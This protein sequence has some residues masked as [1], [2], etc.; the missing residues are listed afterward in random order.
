MLHGRSLL[1]RLTL[2][3]CLFFA[4]SYAADLD[5]TGG[6]AAPARVRFLNAASA[7]HA[8][9]EGGEGWLNV[10]TR[11]AAQDFVSAN[12]VSLDALGRRL[13]ADESL[14]SLQAIVASQQATIA[15]LQATIASQQATISAQATSCTT[16]TQ[17]T[18]PPAPAATGSALIAGLYFIAG[19]YTGS[20]IG[21]RL[22]A[23]WDL[24]ASSWHTDEVPPLTHSR[25][26][27]AA[28]VH[29]GFLYVIG[30][31]G[32]LDSGQAFSADEFQWNNQGCPAP[33]GNTTRVLVDNTDYRSRCLSNAQEPLASVE[34]YPLTGGSWSPVAS[35]PAPMARTYAA[36]LGAHIYVTDE[37]SLVK[38]VPGSD[39]W[40]QCAPLL[41]SHLDPSHGIGDMVAI[42]GRLYLIGNTLRSSSG[43]YQGNGFQGEAYDPNLDT[44]SL[45]APFPYTRNSVQNGR[46]DHGV[47]A[48]GSLLYTIAGFECPYTCPPC[49][50]EPNYVESYHVSAQTWSAL[51]SPPQVLH[52]MNRLARAVGDVVYVVPEGVTSRAN[53]QA[54]EIFAYDTGANSWSVAGSIP[55][56]LEETSMVHI[57]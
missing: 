55:V 31:T 48:V 1:L 22:V 29:D 32:M 28:V 35:M 38:Y 30:G 15:S 57:A 56:R 11:V 6:P 21:S 10:S 39:T 20:S 37:I 42:S 36:S 41:Y 50:S 34:R 52:G 26:S 14:A 5:I 46:L 9:L 2:G 49:C 43:S 25:Q 4:G 17:M 13:E 7:E 47:V 44:W 45:I 18:S 27:A 8:V 51:A 53:S 24:Q 54:S 16:D 23:R 3:A 33:D 40:V 19:K 12:G